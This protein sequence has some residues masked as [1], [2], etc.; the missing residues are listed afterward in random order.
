[1]CHH[2]H[3]LLYMCV[4]IHTYTHIGTHMYIRAHI[5]GRVLSRLLLSNYCWMPEGSLWVC[6]NMCSSPP[7]SNTL[8]GCLTPHT[9][10]NPVCPWGGLQCFLPTPVT[11][12]IGVWVTLQPAL[13]I[14]VSTSADSTTWGFRRTIVCV[15]WKKSA[16]KWTCAVQTPVVQGPPVL[17]FSLLMDGWCMQLGYAGQWDD[18]CP[19][20]VGVRFHQLFRMVVNLKL[21]TCLFLKFSIWYFQTTVTQES[22]TRDKGGLLCMF[23]ARHSL[24]PQG[25]HSLVWR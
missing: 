6:A 21:R 13:C 22:E 2:L 12:P 20:W 5:W 8:C 14:Q 1:M 24:C 25:T 16:S 7:I 18:S 11:C 17:L 3:V 4:Y 9:V 15:Y 19:G 10:S 23:V